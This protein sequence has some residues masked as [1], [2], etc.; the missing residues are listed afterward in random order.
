MNVAFF[1]DVDAEVLALQH[2]PSH[3]EIVA[4]LLETEDVS[5][6]NNDAIETEDE[7]VYSPDRNEPSQIIKTMQKLLIFKR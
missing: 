6:D 1:N 7:S 3:D 5:N 2:Q 4:Q